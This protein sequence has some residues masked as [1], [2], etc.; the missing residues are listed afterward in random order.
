MERTCYTDCADRDRA[1]VKTMQSHTR[2][3]PVDDTGRPRAVALMAILE[4]RS[5]WP[6]SV[7]TL[8]VI[9]DSPLLFI[10]QLARTC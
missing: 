10:N 8:R 4:F 5:V 3:I 1:S 2:L 7:R 6:P 9:Y